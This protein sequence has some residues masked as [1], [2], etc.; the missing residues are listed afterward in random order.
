MN[1]C[2]AMTVTFSCYWHQMWQPRRPCTTAP[3]C[4]RPSIAQTT[5]PMRKPRKPN[6]KNL[7]TACDL[8]LILPLNEN[9]S[10]LCTTARAGNFKTSSV[11]VCSL[12]LSEIRP[13]VRLSAVQNTHTVQKVW[14]WYKMSHA[15]TKYHSRQ[16]GSNS[17]LVGL[18]SAKSI[19]ITDQPH[20]SIS[21]DVV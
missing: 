12:A 3:H 16:W 14:Y 17:I 15:G 1:N 9:T 11:S 8:Q 4:L 18:V 2:S 19:G 10:K 7:G 6:V 21:K 13:L 5:K 20:T